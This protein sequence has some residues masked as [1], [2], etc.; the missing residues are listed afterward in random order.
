MNTG[1]I[2]KDNLRLFTVPNSR[3]P[4]ARC[5]RLGRYDSDLLAQQLIEQRRFSDVGAPHDG[6]IAGAKRRLLNDLA[7]GDFLCHKFH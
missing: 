3:D 2:D 6:N 1:G 7:L 5:L 4:I